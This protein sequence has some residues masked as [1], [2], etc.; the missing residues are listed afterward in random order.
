M[1]NISAGM[2]VFTSIFHIITGGLQKYILLH[3][4][5]SRDF[6]YIEYILRIRKKERGCWIRGL[7]MRRLSM[8]PELQHIMAPS[9][10]GTGSWCL[11]QRQ[12]RKTLRCRWT[13][14]AGHFARALSTVIP[15]RICILEAIR[16][17][18]A[19]ARFHRGSRHRSAASVGLPCSRHRWKK[20]RRCWSI[21][22][23]M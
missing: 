7:S 22:P 6:E 5:C 2:E 16:R 3:V 12:K 19:S 14:R 15:I 21:Y 18:S 11:D 10:S 8:E 4:S 9:G 23:E 13:R 1:S 20:G 17:R